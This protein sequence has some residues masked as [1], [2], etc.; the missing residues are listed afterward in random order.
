MMIDAL[1]AG[2]FPANMLKDLSVSG[3]KLDF[4]DSMI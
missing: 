1:K 2:G 3:G 4:S